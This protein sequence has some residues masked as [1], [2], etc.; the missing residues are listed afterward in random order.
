MAGSS[1]SKP[2]VGRLQLRLWKRTF[3]AAGQFSYEPMWDVGHGRSDAYPDPGC[4]SDGTQHHERG[5][6]PKR[7]LNLADPR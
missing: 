5:A 2:V 6:C 3:A 4:L 7:L 1:R